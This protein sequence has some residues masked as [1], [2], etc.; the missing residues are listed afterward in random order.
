MVFCFAILWSV[1]LLGQSQDSVADAARKNRHQPKDLQ[2]S[3]N[4]AKKVWTNDDFGYAVPPTGSATA[5]DTHTGISQVR[6]EARGRP[7]FELCRGA[8]GFR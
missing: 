6:S 4:A 1:P 2:A 5:K 8:N 7:V 3:Q